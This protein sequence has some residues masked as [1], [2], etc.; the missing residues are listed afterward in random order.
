MMPLIGI[1]TINYNNCNGLSRT[2]QSVKG[3]NER[4]IEFVVIDGGSSDGSVDVIN[5]NQDVITKWVSEP[6][7][8]IYHAMNKG[9]LM[10]TSSF[11]LF[12][13]SGDSLES[14]SV[15]SLVCS[16]LS[17]NLG[18]LYG[19][20]RMIGQNRSFLRIPSPEMSFYDFINRRSP[21]HQSTFI[22]RSLFETIGL[23]NEELKILADWEFFM[24]AIFLHGCVIKY[25]P[26]VIARFELDGVS[27]RKEN[28][29]L[30]HAEKNAIL[31]RYFPRFRVDYKELHRYKNLANNSI[32]MRACLR[33][34]KL[35][36]TNI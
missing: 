30:L 11:L 14:N 10:S 2:I 23:Y 31:D 24:K 32:L 4:N 21:H 20:S 16:Q 13:N 36:K 9:I 22:N 12:L 3:Q 28:A 5:C 1:I 6:D 34:V 18:L 27:S 15:L 33:I 7:N 35:F 19:N 8:G 25:V 29:E 17:N 26:E